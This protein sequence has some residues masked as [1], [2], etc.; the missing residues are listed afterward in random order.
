MAIQSTGYTQSKANYSLFTRHHGESFIAV[1]IYVDDIV[2]TGNDLVAIA[3]LKRILH[4][5]F[6]IKDLGDLKFFLGIEV[7]RS[8][9]GIF[10]S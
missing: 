2:I 10:L 1:L 9:K 6:R 8:H 4:S 3:A 5:Q 7:A